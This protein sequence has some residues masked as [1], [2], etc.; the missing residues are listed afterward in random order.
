LLIC[1]DLLLILQPASA[2]AHYSTPAPALSAKKETIA[3]AMAP[4][5][6]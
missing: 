5:L 1:P 4:L 6:T 3:R 2:S